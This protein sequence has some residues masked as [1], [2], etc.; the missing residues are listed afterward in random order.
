MAYGNL[1]SQNNRIQ[2]EMNQTKSIKT[3]NLSLEK[4]KTLIR[5]VSTSCMD[6]YSNIIGWGYLS[7]F[8]EELDVGLHC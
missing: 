6:A 1:S 5:T 2:I 8:P 7:G 3:L 4:K